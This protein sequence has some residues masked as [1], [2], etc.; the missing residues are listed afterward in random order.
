VGVGQELA[1]EPGR[2]WVS[3]Y[4]HNG[5]FELHRPWWI[6]G[7]EVDGECRDIFCAALL[8]TSEEDCRSLISFCHDSGLEPEFRFI[9]ARAGDWSPFCDRFQRAAW[10]VWP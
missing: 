3:W 2:W 1:P 7:Y 6:S 9:E 5:T 10:M 4:G 8:A